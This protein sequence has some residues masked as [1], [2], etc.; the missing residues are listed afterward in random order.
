MKNKG[1]KEFKTALRSENLKVT[2][3][4]LTVF[5]E[6]F[7]NEEHQDAEDIFIALQISGKNEKIS[8]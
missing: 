7:S 1:I 3:Q 5:E 8:S 6:V 2:L 4:R